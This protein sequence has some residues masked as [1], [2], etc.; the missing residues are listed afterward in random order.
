MNQ[1]I[2]Q[3]K[4]YRAWAYVKTINPDLIKSDISFTA[5]KNGGQGQ[6]TLTIS[7]PF[8]DSDYN[9]WDIIKV[10]V[11]NKYQSSYL[12]YTWFIESK[13]QKATN[14]ETTDIYCIGIVWLLK[15]LFYRNG[16]SDRKF[17]KNTTALA[18]LTEIIT[19]FNTDSWQSF[20]INNE[21]DLSQTV[22]LEFDNTYCFDAIKKVMDTVDWY[23]LL[24]QNGILN[25]KTT[26]IKHKAT[27]R[28]N[29]Q[30]L[31]VASDWQIYNRLYLQWWSTSKVYNDTTS[32][33][34]YWIREKAIN[35]TSLKDTWTMDE[36]AAKRLSE[37]AYPRDKNRLTIT[38][39]YYAIVP[40]KWNN[41]WI[42]DDTWLWNNKYTWSNYWPWWS[43]EAIQP[44]DWLRVQNFY[45]LIEW[46]IERIWY[47]NGFIDIELDN[48]DNFI[49]LI[50][51]NG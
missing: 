47:K 2:Y 11:T 32:Q 6:M 42:R 49:D 17:T 31:T 40:L 39:E 27:Y 51:T 7:E 5:N 23:W 44:W 24:D 10:Y 1:N 30:S 8:Q 9:Y 21:I 46:T 29:I 43:T 35:D 34:I 15:G 45:S 14:S 4:Q 12:L 3:I 38:S 36:F 19:N 25:I 28:K 33:S 37:N 50:K 22:H 26:T 18:I 41:L 20:T 13:S 48:F 16:W